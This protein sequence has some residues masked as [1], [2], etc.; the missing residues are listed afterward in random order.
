M[1]KRR[2]LP[3]ELCD[4]CKNKPLVGETLW[5]SGFAW[6]CP[7]CLIE[8]TSGELVTD[9]MI[10]YSLKVQNELSLSKRAEEA[11]DQL[12]AKDHQLMADWHAQAEDE[13][14]RYA[15]RKLP[16]QNVINGEV[17]QSANGWLKDT[18]ANPD[19]A[20]IDSSLTR[21]KLLD[22]NDVAALGI[23]VSHTVKAK[24]T[25]EKLISH[26]LALAHKVAFE[27]TSKAQYERDPAIEI[28]RLNIASRMMRTAQDAAI[29]LQNL[30]SSGPQ[31]I[32]VQH[33]NIGSGGQAVVGNVSNKSITKK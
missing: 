16:I 1:P 18:L 24:N 17:A 32:T 22:A 9:K 19:L 3:P 11:G 25:A 30:K 27:Q 29:T 21:G 12:K 8:T 28:K 15:K 20:A 14:N 33:V 6:I 4:V 2:Y 23:D 5:H 31:N 7:S 13:I 10:H 26:Q